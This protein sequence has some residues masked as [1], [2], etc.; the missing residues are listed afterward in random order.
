[1]RNMS[2]KRSQ[3]KCEKSKRRKQ[4]KAAQQNAPHIICMYVC[5]L[6]NYYTAT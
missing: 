5:I 1:M 4:I 6:T 2:T 3:T